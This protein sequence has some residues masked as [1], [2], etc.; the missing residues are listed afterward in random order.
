MTVTI[1]SLRAKMRAERDPKKKYGIAKQVIAA[2]RQAEESGH[3]APK[4][5]VKPIKRQDPVDSYLEAK[6]R[7]AAKG[8]TPP[9][10]AQPTSTARKHSEGAQDWPPAHLRQRVADAQRHQ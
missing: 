10:P 7:I 1:E 3:A 4:P 2:L 8:G 6:K 5:V 9:E